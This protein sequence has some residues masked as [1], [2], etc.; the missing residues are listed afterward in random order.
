MSTNK[1]MTLVLLLPLLAAFIYGVI[2][3]FHLT[4]AVG[5]IYPP[6]SSLR[7][8][9]LGSRAFYESLQNLS[10]VS[11]NRNYQ[12]LHNLQTESATSVFFL[13]V[14]AEN[15]SW[16]TEE[17]ARDL[18]G[19]VK[20]GERLIIAFF[21]ST[22]KESQEIKQKEERMEKEKRKGEKERE[23]EDPGQEEE[24]E[25]HFHALSLEK[26]WG[27][28]LEYANVS[29]DS[30]NSTALKAVLHQEAPPIE[31]SVSWHT[32]LYFDKLDPAWKAIYTQK[33]RPVVIERKLGQGTLVLSADSYFLSNEAL[34]AERCP[35]LL[36]WL[37]GENTKMIFDET[38]LGVSEEP[39]LATLIKK[40]RLHGLC[41]GF[42][43]LAI[44]FIWKNAFS[45]VPPYEDEIRD[46][47]YSL[48]HGKDEAAGLL[49]II[50]RN[51]PH[52][53]ILT[54]C[55]DEWKKMSARTKK[56]SQA[57]LDQ[58]RDILARKEN[59][60]TSYNKISRILSERK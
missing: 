3:L 55:F 46:Q 42:I 37:V 57:L 4:F 56:I 49:N 51:I 48:A 45:F 35:A 26:K 18:E 44:L 15:F 25:E 41:A 40:Y 28:Y 39:S 19:W 1:R 33:D 50:R 5:N 9:P 54:L 53:H 43:L 31:K 11:V 58:I 38:H 30:D 60:V 2:E 34:R 22:R 32:T 7:A 59:P 8:D 36:S 10:T 27:V 16:V 23:K 47:T 6:Y 52:H 12:P 24:Q 21:P 14:D 20:S 13:G 17:E 29:I